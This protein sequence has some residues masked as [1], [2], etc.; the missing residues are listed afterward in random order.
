MVVDTTK[1]GLCINRIIGQKNESLICEGDVIIPDIKPDII[2]AMNTSGIVC[3]YKKEVLDGKIR[4]DGVVQIYITYLADDETGRVRGLN[5][6]LDFTEIVDLQGV[7]PGMQ[8]DEEVNIKSIECKVLNGRKINVIANLELNVKVYFND[9]VDLVKDINNIQDIQKLSNTYE[10]NSQ[11]GFG[12]SKTYAKETVIIDNVDNLAEILM[13]DVKIVNKDFKISYNKVLAKADAEVKMM[14]LTQDNRINTVESKIPVMGFIDIPNVDET[15]FCDL[16]YKLK[17]VVIK[18][19]SEEEHSIYV[20]AEIE[21]ICFAYEKK[22]VNIIQDLYSPSVN[23][24]FNR[25]VIDTVCYTNCVKDICMIKEKVE[26]PELQEGKIYDVETNANILSEK[27]TENNI[28]YEGEIILKFVFS[29]NSV[30]GIDVKTIN[31]PFTFSENIDGINVGSTIETHIDVQKSNFINEGMGKVNLQVD[32]EFTISSSNMK[33]INVIDEI[34]TNE[35]EQEDNYSM[36]I[37]FVKKGDTLWKIAKEF[38]STVDDIKRV[39]G[40]E[41]ENVIDVGKQ[42]FIPRYSAIRTA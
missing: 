5:T 30:A 10:L 4:I 25:K 29:T 34:E 8:L 24:N 36:V 33:R 41:N 22:E 13:A 12:S 26:L 19:N 18:P 2:S 23:M 40:I 3:V 15:N 16:K 27:I 32:L 39:N 37:Y 42:L 35:N 21:L 31:V 17:N 9:N 14:Y 6:V 11:V 1:E 7:K 28:I 20:E 38:K